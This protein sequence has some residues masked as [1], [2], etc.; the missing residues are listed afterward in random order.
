MGL[1][2]NSKELQFRRTKERNTFWKERGWVL[3]VV[4]WKKCFGIIQ[5]FH[6]SWLLVDWVMTDSHGL[7]Y[8]WGMVETFLLLLG[9][10]VG[11]FPLSLQ[12]MRSGRMPQLPCWPPKDVSVRL[13]LVFTAFKV[14]PCLNNCIF[15]M[16]GAFIFPSFL[17]ISQSVH[18]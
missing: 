18:P 17:S 7:G 15:F 1:F 4:K 5:E 10:K 8:Y 16:V 13:P 2:R 14:Y 3:G 12:L 11:F 6:V 9:S